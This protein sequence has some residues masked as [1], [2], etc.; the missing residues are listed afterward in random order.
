MCTSCQFI[1]ECEFF[2]LYDI[3]CVLCEAFIFCTIVINVAVFKARCSTGVGI[4]ILYSIYC[5][6]GDEMNFQ[7]FQFVYYNIYLYYYDIVFNGLLL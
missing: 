2:I 7:F 6:Y 5:V 4:D 1:T 3:S